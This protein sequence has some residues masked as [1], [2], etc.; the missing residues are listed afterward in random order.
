MLSNQTQRSRLE[1]RSVMKML[2]AEKRKP[3]EISERVMCME[4]LL[5]KNIY[6]CAKHGFATTSLRRKDTQW[7][8]K[9]LTLR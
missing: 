5:V 8:E 9:R 2:A 4:N 6:K 3:F 7:N 1:Q